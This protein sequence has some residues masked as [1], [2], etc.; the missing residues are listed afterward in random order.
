MPLYKPGRAVWVST[1]HRSQIQ[2]LFRVGQVLIAAPAL[3]TLTPGQVFTAR[4]KTASTIH[5][6]RLRL[7][8]NNEYEFHNKY[9]NY[10]CKFAF[11]VL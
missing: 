8:A 3:L 4:R 7:Q 2:L 5:P 6:N 11:L 10:P 1:A 9:Q